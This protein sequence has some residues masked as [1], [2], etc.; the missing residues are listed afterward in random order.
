VGIGFF[1][2]VGSAYYLNNCPGETGTWLAVTGNSIGPGDMIHT[3]L[4]THFI[5]SSSLQDCEDMLC[6][7]MSGLKNAR[8]ESSAEAVAEIL[9]NFSSPVPMD[10]GPLEVNRELIDK[11]F[12]HNSIMEIL[13]SL[14]WEE[15]EWS[16]ETAK[17]ILGRS[18]I[19]VVVSLQHLRRAKGQDFDTI[20]ARDFTLAQHFLTEHDFY[21]GVRAAVIDKDKQPQWNPARLED[22]TEKDVAR[23]FSPTGNDLE[24][25][26]I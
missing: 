14:R 1:P 15:S 2:D 12:A 19:S 11:C 24:A 10:P 3:G 4:A 13:E 22:I 6:R 20:I 8:Q 16:H 7:A 9:E 26:A 25:F 5:P 17:T 23:Y 21:E 18:P